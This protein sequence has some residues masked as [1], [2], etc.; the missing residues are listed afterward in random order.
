MTE[1]SPN[2]K[3]AAVLGFCLNVFGFKVPKEDRYRN[4]RTL[5]KAVLR[6]TRKN[7]ARIHS[8]DP[9]IAA[10]CLVAGFSYE[11]ENLRLVHTRAL[12]MRRVESVDY[13]Y[14]DPPLGG[15]SQDL[16]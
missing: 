14:V 5:Q 15:D 6:W 8:Y 9:K 4:G 10:A 1:L 12:G 13:F 3:G 11:P 7:F 16:E 2:Y